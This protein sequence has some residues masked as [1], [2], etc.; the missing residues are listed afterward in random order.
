ME[1][2]TFLFPRAF[3][4]PIYGTSRNEHASI[5]LLATLQWRFSNLRLQLRSNVLSSNVHDP[6]N[7]NERDFCH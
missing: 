5:S 2:R 6:I 3:T 4:S 1:E 7:N